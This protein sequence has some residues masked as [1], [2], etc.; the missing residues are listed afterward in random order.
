MSWLDK[1]HPS[2]PAPVIKMK[3]KSKPV[4]EFIRMLATTEP[5]ETDETWWQVRLLI[6]YPN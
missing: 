6:M 3:G 5:I 2:D 1:I 4:L